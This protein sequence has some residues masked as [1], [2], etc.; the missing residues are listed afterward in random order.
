MYF[1]LGP[2]SAP[3]DQEVR[4]YAKRQSTQLTRGPTRPSQGGRQSSINNK[5]NNSS[6]RDNYGIRPSNDGRP[7]ARQPQKIPNNNNNNIST[8]RIASRYGGIDTG[9]KQPT[10]PKDPAPEGQPRIPLRPTVP[11]RLPPKPVVRPKV[12]ALYA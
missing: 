4:Q 11:M 8:G 12:R 2:S 5:F 3:I 6:S 1:F 9:F 7:T 10:P